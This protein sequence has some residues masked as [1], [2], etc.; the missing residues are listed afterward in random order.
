MKHLLLLNLKAQVFWRNTFSHWDAWVTDLKRG[1]EKKFGEVQ[2]CNIFHV[3]SIN[4]TTTMVFSRP[5]DY[6]EKLLLGR[7]VSGVTVS[8]AAT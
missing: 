2:N 3:R 1:I 5:R 8:V 6:G 4:W 7:D